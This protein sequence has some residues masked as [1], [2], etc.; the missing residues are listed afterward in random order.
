VNSKRYPWR[1]FGILLGAGLLGVVAIMPYLLAALENLPAAASL[2]PLHVLLFFQF[3]QSA[4]LL[5]I[6]VG[7]GLWLARRIGCGAPILE[8][9]LTG[10]KIGDRLRAIL[11]P[12]LATGVG[13][14][15]AVLLL[16]KFVFIPVI[17]QLGAVWGTHI[18]IWKKLL[19]SFY[20]GI[21][22]ELL[23]RLF[24]FSLLAWLLSKVWRTQNGLPGPVSFWLANVISAIFFGLGHLGTAPIMGIPITPMVITAALVLNGIAGVAFGYLY[25]K[26]GLEAAMIA[27]FSADIVLQGFGSLLLGG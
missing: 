14:G 12:S 3:L 9:W 19:A 17:P 21:V 1:V 4:V 6:A 16:L 8:A 23:M 25:W 24:L 7:A 2:P 11:Q 27:H 15:A 22:E 20:G 13:V 10:E 18:A 5:A 26:R